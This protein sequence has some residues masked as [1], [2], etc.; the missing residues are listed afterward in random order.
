[1]YTFTLNQSLFKRYFVSYQ[2]GRKTGQGVTEAVTYPLE[3]ENGSS[4]WLFD[5]QFSPDGRLLLFKYG[6][7]HERY[8]GYDLYVWDLNA[9]K[10]Q[11]ITRLVYHFVL[12]SP[13]GRYVA[14]VRG[15]DAD[16]NPAFSELQLYTYD[17]TT[18]QE[19]L[20]VQNNGIRGGIAWTPQN[21]L[22]YSVLT[23][24]RPL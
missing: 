8:V 11:R 24:G 23:P 15:A 14:Y 9:R 19:H 20:I 18:K 12:W 22:L 6:N 4:D 10:M 5:P 7:L 3:A 13:N 2:T 16:G 1:M 17:I 21:T